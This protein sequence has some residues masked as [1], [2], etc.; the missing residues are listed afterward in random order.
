MWHIFRHGHHEEEINFI[1]KSGAIG[2]DVPIQD[3]VD[4]AREGTLIPLDIKGTAKG[5]GEPVAWPYH[6]WI[7]G[8][9]TLRIKRSFQSEEGIVEKGTYQIRPPL[10]DLCVSDASEEEQS[11]KSANGHL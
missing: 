3:E 6:D 9:I 7:T 10:G 4:W 5:K 1:T 11:S 2:K 8:E